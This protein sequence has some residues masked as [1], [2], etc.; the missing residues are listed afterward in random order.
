MIGTQ[1]QHVNCTMLLRRD[2]RY[3]FLWRRGDAS[4]LLKLF[5]KFAVNAELSFT[6]LDAAT[7]SR[8]VRD[9]LRKGD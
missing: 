5:G 9:E 1:P 2:E 4:E 6:W 8:R 3:V 7:L